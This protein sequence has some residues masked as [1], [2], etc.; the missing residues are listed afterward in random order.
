MI[1]NARPGLRAVT[2]LLIVA[3]SGFLNIGTP[4]EASAQ[5]PS[6]S[7]AAAPAGVTS[8][9]LRTFSPNAA[10]SAA[11][12]QTLTNV[13]SR[14]WVGRHLVLVGTLVGA[15]V[16]VAVDAATCMGCGRL[17]G[18]LTG[19]IT[20]ATLGAVASAIR[21]SRLKYQAPSTPPDISAVSRVTHRFGL[22]EGIML[23][24]SDSR[25]TIGTVQG[26]GPDRIA[27]MPDSRPGTSVEIPYSQVR[28][29]SAKPSH[30]GR[31]IATVA[32]AVG[33][34][35]LVVC[36]TRPCGGV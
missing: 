35:A 30:L 8:H 14:R 5:S 10:I 3:I 29:L 16:G 23:T 26:L 13:S 9:V 19:V 15:G 32:V 21:Q 27:V 33:L 6:S 24:T 20:G 36:A 2:Y 31:K 12:D 4:A 18:T 25:R 22:G 28:T 1:S 7:Q 17:G 34:G 11:Q